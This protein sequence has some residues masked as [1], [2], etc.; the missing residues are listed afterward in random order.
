MKLLLLALFMSLPSQASDFKFV[1]LQKVD[2]QYRQYFPGGRHYLITH[3]GLPDR[4]LDKGVSIEANTDILKYLYW[5]NLI[6]SLTDKTSEGR[7]QFRSV[8]WEF[9][10]GVRALPFLS[11]EYYHHSQHVLDISQE[12]GFPV[13]DAV[14]FNIHLFDSRT[15]DALLHF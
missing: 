13:E 15:K 10:L 4:S 2:I 1:E 12:R 3:N 11:V 6:H 7:G 9:K 8:G 5:N 14:N